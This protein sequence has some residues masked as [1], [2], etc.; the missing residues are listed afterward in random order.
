V[1]RDTTAAQSTVA[2][3]S[4]EALR[5]P[6]P[7]TPSSL[8]ATA[9]DHGSLD[10][11]AW[12]QTTM[13]GLHEGAMAA[14]VSPHWNHASPIVERFAEPRVDTS[15][16]PPALVLPENWDHTRSQFDASLRTVEAARATVEAPVAPPAPVALPEPQAA[17]PPPVAAPAPADTPPPSAPVAA[18]VAS[19]APPASA[20][21]PSPAAPGPVVAGMEPLFLRM[22]EGV[23]DV[24][25]ARA[26]LKNGFRMPATLIRRSENNPLKFA[27]TAHEAM[28]RLLGEPSDAF[29]S[30]EA[31]IV[32]AM[33]DIRLHQVAL[34]AGVRAAFD[35]L[36][37]QFDPAHF[38]DD[39]ERRGRFSFGAGRG[40][41]ERYRAHFDKLAADP[42]DRFR[43]LFGD[44]FA[45]AYE[46]QLAQ[47]RRDGQRTGDGR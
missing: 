35:D 25:R 33:D 15:A 7:V 1:D 26:E 19:T 3:L 44:E 8:P 28:S 36:M 18:P 10:P 11:L 17:I 31:A 22:L 24:L 39:G 9:A 47:H 27:P 13:P 12:F 41:W 45:R 46:D 5:E 38:D 6:A 40:A 4:F 43:R 42:E 37:G 30:G 32:D 14:E 20:A 16:P 34:L 23:M 29:L 2:P 21:T